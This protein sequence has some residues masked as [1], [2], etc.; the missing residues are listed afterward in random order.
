MPQGD[1]YRL[2]IS[3][4]C[5]ASDSLTGERPNKKGKERKRRFGFSSRVFN[6]QVLRRVNERMYLPNIGIPLVSVIIEN[7]PRLP[8][9]SLRD[10]NSSCRV[11]ASPKSVAWLPTN[12]SYLFRTSF[13]VS[14]LSLSLSDS[15]RR[16]LASASA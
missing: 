4:K 12:K 13:F 11:R 5:I 7:G 14:F 10:Q 1:I 6:P 15:N 16:C 9:S 2:R 8:K 3:E